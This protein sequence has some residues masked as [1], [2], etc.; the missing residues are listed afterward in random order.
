MSIL[1]HL[2]ALRKKPSV[3][4]LTKKMVLSVVKTRT[5]PSWKQWKQ[6]PRTL[7][8]NE[9]RVSLCA[10]LVMGISL[11]VLGG[12]YVIVHQTV[13][14]AVG[15]EYTEALIGNPQFIN[16]LYA[17][18]SDVD[19]DLTRL[20]FSGL[21]QYDIN[22]GLTTDLAESYDISDDGKTYT[23]VLRQGAKWHD[24]NPVTVSDVVGTF[25]LLQN[26]EYKSPLSVSFKD[27]SISEIDART[28]Q[29]TLKEPFAPFLSALTVGLLPGS[30][31]DLIPAKNATLAE[32]NLRPIGS[33]PYRFDK[34]SKDRLGNIRSYTLERNDDFYGQSPKISKL[35]FRF[36]PDAQSA[37]DALQKQHVDGTSF[38]PSTEIEPLSKDRDLQLLFPTLPQYT[39]VFFN[40]TKVP[41]LKEASVRT[42][43]TQAIN[44]QL[45]VEQVLRNHARTVDGPIL[46][47]MLGFSS[48]I[49]QP[50]FDL[51]TA[52]TAI[53]TY[54]ATLKEGETFKLTITTI[55]SQEFVDVATFIKTAWSAVGVET[56]LRLV[57]ADRLPADVLKNRDY[58]VLLAGELLGSDPDLYAFWH[59]SQVDYPG[60]NIALYQNKKADTL[61]EEARN[62]IDSNVRAEKYL[63]FQQLLMTDLPAVFLYQPTYTY[64]TSSKIKGVNLPFIL[65]PAD[66]FADVE[67]WYIETKHVLR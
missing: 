8:T 50:A 57:T 9:R 34:F 23:F 25:S 19:A 66:R 2:K 36:Y 16:P 6:L 61:L 20:V 37:V 41:A 28:V 7:T 52:Q 11:F 32:I 43:L 67:T 24:G 12:R 35:T 40:D 3:Q 5:I 31:W 49:K 62:A 64:A 14:P 4:D 22:N 59:S 56:E 21:M 48:D 10:I 30:A 29:F 38:V 18:V 27:V 60:L 39:A 17:S 26:P 65:T 54:K 42:A 44:R 46:P 33:G 47:N 58:D 55:D 45:L 51:V 53:D 13:V 63:A 15:G 1:N